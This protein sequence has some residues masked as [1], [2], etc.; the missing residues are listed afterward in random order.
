MLPHSDKMEDVTMTT[1]QFRDRLETLSPDDRES[2]SDVLEAFGAPLLEYCDRPDVA[3][4]TVSGDVDLDDACSCALRAIT[5][6]ETLTTV[7]ALYQRRSPWRG[8]CTGDPDR[9]APAVAHPA[10]RLNTVTDAC[11]VHPVTVTG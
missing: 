8:G 4:A 5:R 6:G 10:T 9:P 3:D 7:H 2:Y 11:G 1:A